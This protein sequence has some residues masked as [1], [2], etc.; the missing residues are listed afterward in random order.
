MKSF[1]SAIKFEEP[2]RS[3]GKQKTTEK[4][5]KNNVSDNIS[6]TEILKEDSANSFAATEI[7]QENT[8]Y[9]KT[10]EDYG[11]TELLL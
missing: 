11:E 8:A 3:L 5:K 7:L 10:K 2:G 4:K 9:A 6:A 1:S